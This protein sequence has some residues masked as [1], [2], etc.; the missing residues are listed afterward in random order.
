MTLIVDAREAPRSLLHAQMTI[1]VAPGDLTLFYPKWVPGEHGP[2]NPLSNLAS[3]RV[4]AGGSPLQ[5]QRDLVDM[6]AFHVRVPDGTTLLRASFDFLMTQDDVSGTPDMLVLNWN[7]VLLYPAG[8]PVAQLR[9]APSII[10]PDR[11]QYGTA[12]TA[13]ARNGDRLDFDAVSVETLVDSPLDAG[14]YFRRLTLLD[15]PSATNEVDIF[16][17]AP[18]DLEFDSDV[19]AKLKRLVAQTD[20]LYGARHW[21]HYHF[22]LTLSDAI[23][24]TGIEHHESS[25][26]RELDAYLT[27]PNK[28][29]YAGDL[30]AHEFS[31]SW[32]GK[33]RRPAG[34]TTTDYQMPEKTDLLWVYEGL[35]QYIGDVLSYRTG[36]RDAK[37][38]PEFLASLYGGLEYEPG[39]LSTPLS[40]VAVS[41][42][43]LYQ[44]PKQWTEERR[45]TDDFYN[46]GELVWLEADT[47]MRRSSNGSKSL[48]SF[49][50]N[51]F[52]QPSSGPM[53]RTYTY[54]DIVTAL[55]AVQAYDWDAFFRARV[56]TVMAHPP[57]EWIPRSGYRLTFTDVPNS[58]DALAED[59]RNT[60]DLRY[61]LGVIVKS[62]SDDSSPG[63]VL[64]VLTG[65]PAA[66]AG[67]GAGVKIVAV[68]W[69]TFS[70]SELHAVVKASRRA[71]EP[72]TLIV[73]S[74]KTFKLITIDYHGG[75]RYPHL[76]R[77]A[78]SQDLLQAITAPR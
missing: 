52:G 12:L 41:A 76:E 28:F 10:L 40:E 3:L 49:L 15:Q 1:P 18:S 74:G 53:V 23:A 67:L 47:I 43:F 75:D 62:E 16:A 48:D 2:T 26:N 60:I 32:N 70:A 21:T 68:N 19:E 34:L 24:P 73:Q 27:D 71:A 46:E 63:E 42:P 59:A 57:S 17:A 6:Y 20:A 8:T 9:V 22:L 37:E 13:H 29:D 50:R 55:T 58:V 7:R 5:W 11:W 69:R 56:Y 44:A 35:N 54:Q 61:S 31:H 30:L 66:K 65:S 78:G 38:Y 45:N 36:M 64:D 39:R 77:N 51:F 33:Y 72:I 4:E 25:D 14:R